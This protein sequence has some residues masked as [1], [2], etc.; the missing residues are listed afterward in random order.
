MDVSPGQ[1]GLYSWFEEHGVELVHP[2][3]RDSLRE[4]IPHCK[5]FQVVSND[6]AYL[7]LRQGDKRYRVSPDLFTLIAAPLRSFGQ[8]VRVRKGGEVIR[9]TVRD[10]MWHYKRAE[11]MYFL[12]ANGK[13]LKKQY[14]GADFLDESE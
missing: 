6:G 1:W 2:N 9:A 12:L 5:V 3:D 10:I 14:W 13:K 7:T 4:L 8:S 11:P